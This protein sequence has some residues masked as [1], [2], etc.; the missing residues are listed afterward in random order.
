MAPWERAGPI[1][2]RTVDQND[3]LL[4]W[5]FPIDE[6]AKDNCYTIDSNN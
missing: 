2:Q 6:R 4:S 1:T 3:L 5:L